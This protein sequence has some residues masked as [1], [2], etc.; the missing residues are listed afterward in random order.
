MTQNL[1]VFGICCRPYVDNDVIS[2]VAVDSAGVDIRIKFGDSRSNRF[3][4]IRGADFVSNERKLA[5]PNSAKRN[6]VSPKNVHVRPYTYSYVRLERDNNTRTASCVMH[7]RRQ[8]QLRPVFGVKMQIMYNGLQKQT[9][10]HL[11][12]PFQK[13]KTVNLF[14]ICSILTE[15][16]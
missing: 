10:T 4:D 16:L 9:M 8:V 6:C 1:H 15:K 5:Y 13:R 11:N 7:R 2:G 3:R 12:H 14:E